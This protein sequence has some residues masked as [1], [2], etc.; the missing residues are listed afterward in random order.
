MWSGGI[1]IRG[2]CDQSRATDIPDRLR[3]LSKGHTVGEQQTSLS[4]AGASLPV[5][6]SYLGVALVLQ[7]AQAWCHLPAHSGECQSVHLSCTTAALRATHSYPVPTPMFAILNHPTCHATPH[8]HAPASSGPDMQTPPPQN[9]KPAPAG[10]PP[11]PALPHL[12][13]PMRPSAVGKS[14]AGVFSITL[15]IP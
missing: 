13:L 10:L 8:L 5:A 9:L 3:T 2:L 6:T 14:P 7:H 11:D 15:S 1:S 12:M 4:S